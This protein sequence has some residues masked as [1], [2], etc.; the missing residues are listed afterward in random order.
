MNI[1]F[2]DLFN[3]GTQE[4]PSSV[5]VITVVLIKPGGGRNNYFICQDLDTNVI[6]GIIRRQ[7]AHQR[8][9]HW[10]STVVVV[11]VV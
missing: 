7:A 4:I 8:V 2:D 9:T 1:F 6:S 3:L 5:L 10:W 11:V